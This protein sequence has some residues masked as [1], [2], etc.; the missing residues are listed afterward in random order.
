MHRFR[1]VEVEVRAAATPSRVPG[2][3]LPPTPW[4]A[5]PA[6]W[7]TSRALRV[8][9]ST[10]WLLATVLMPSNWMAGWWPARMMAMASSAP[11]VWFW[12]VRV[13]VG[14]GDA[15]DVDPAHGVMGMARARGGG[16]WG[17]GRC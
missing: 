5:R 1:R 13:V 14:G 11:H 17:G 9:L 12:C 15:L 7:S 10:V 4:S 16:P 6:K 8:T 3:S 2:R